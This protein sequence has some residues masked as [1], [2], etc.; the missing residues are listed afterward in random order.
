M[1][2][3]HIWIEGERA[4]G[5]TT[6]ARGLIEYFLSEGYKPY[7]IEYIREPEPKRDFARRIEGKRIV[8]WDGVVPLPDVSITRRINVEVL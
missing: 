7:Q 4:S 1:P 2:Q 5:K 8:I 3:E 6:I